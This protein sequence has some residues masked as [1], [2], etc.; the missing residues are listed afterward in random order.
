MQKRF[1]ID[2]WIGPKYTYECCSAA[3]TYNPANLYFFKI[4]NRNTR[5]KFEICLNT[6]MTSFWCF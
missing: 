6:S 2:V 3:V 1:I 5:K 4:S